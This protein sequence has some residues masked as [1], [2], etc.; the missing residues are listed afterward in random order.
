MNNLYKSVNL[1]YIRNFIQ[2]ELIRILLQEQVGSDNTNENIFRNTKDIN[3]F[4]NKI[5]A[6]DKALKNKHHCLQCKKTFNTNK[7]L[8]QHIRAVHIKKKPSN[9]CP[10]CGKK[11]QVKEA[12]E[13]HKRQKHDRDEQPL[14]FECSQCYL[15][16]GKDQAL[17]THM[18]DKHK[19]G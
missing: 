4:I 6:R 7:S 15:R 14:R 11:F 5:H 12:V 19:T 8:Q 16:F 2:R 3:E 1:P 18:R 13:N 9:L 10:I 17:K